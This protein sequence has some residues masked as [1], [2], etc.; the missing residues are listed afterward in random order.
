M[1]AWQSDAQERADRVPDFQQKLERTRSLLGVPGD[2]GTV[3]EHA[4]NLEEDASSFDSVVHSQGFAFWW[5]QNLLR[6]CA[7][8]WELCWWIERLWRFEGRDNV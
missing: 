2:D 3:D 8:K 5:G 1:C 7:R 6:W 4:E